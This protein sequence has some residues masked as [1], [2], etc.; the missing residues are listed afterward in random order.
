[1]RTRRVV[2]PG[3]AILSIFLSACGGGDLT[4]PGQD[5]L[6]PARLLA[7]SGDGQRAEAGTVLDQPL[8]VQVVDDSAQP[9]ARTVVHFGFLGDFSGAS[10]DPDSVLTDSTGRAQ[11]VVRLGDMVGEHVVIAEVA[12]TQ[13]AELR[14][15][16]TVISVAADP[17]GRGRGHGGQGDD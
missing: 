11:A 12:N 17:G 1:M 14:A 15:L 8:A 5:G 7:V 13:S 3:A 2:C 9:V 10:L 6:A 4:L 16:F